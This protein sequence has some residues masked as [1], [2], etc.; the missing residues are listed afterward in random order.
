MAKRKF[1]RKSK[2]KLHGGI[3]DEGT[4]RYY[5]D[6]RVRDA[7]D[8]ND[9]PGNKANRTNTGDTDIRDKERDRLDDE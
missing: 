1:L 3:Q 5:S 9:E 6:P 7:R 8:A 2:R 4:A